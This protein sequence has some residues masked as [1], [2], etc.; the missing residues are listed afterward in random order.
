MRFWYILVDRP[1]LEFQH[2]YSN[3]CNLFQNSFKFQDRAIDQVF[4]I[5]QIG[6]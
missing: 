4:C 5:Y 1:T 3:M 2:G 6:W